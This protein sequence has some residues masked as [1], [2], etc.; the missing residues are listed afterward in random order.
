[1]SFAKRPPAMAA[2]SFVELPSANKKAVAGLAP[3]GGFFF[4]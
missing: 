4:A 1:M 3:C 2:V